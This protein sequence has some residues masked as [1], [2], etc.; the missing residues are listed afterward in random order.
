MKTK[1]ISVEVVRNKNYQSIKHS[2]TITL[3]ENDN[4][5]EI[6]NDLFY[7]LNKQCKEDLKMIEQENK[8]PEDEVEIL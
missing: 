2:A 3:E 4:E 6:R 7:E 5:E 1:E 8:T